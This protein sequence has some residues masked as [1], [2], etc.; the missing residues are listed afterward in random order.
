MTSSRVEEILRQIARLDVNER[1][2][3]LSRLQA[4]QLPL[5]DTSEN[6]KANTLI[7]Q[8]DWIILFD[9]GSI[10]NPGHGYGSYAIRENLAKPSTSLSNRS[11]SSK[12]TR[13]AKTKGWE[14]KRL[15]FGNNVTNNEAEYATLMNALDDVQSRIELNERLAQ[16]FSIEIRGDSLLVINQIS[17]EWK[18]KDDRMRS[19]R[20]GV[21]KQIARFKANRL[22]QH[23]REESVRV[24]G[25]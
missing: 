21:R 15:E 24:L 23:P 5:F 16:E 13:P 20:D 2:D 8:A 22:V 1:R 12:S 18:A 19:L 10:G 3:L 9:G 7:G 4:D 11:T 25:H 14:I 17:G 6:F